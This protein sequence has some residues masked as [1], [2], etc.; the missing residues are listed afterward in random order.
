[1]ATSKT[2]EFE[3]YVKDLLECPGCS[4]S[5][6]LAPI[7]QCINGH[8]ICKHCIT[9]LEDCPICEN[10]SKIARNLVFEQIIGN[11][12][13]SQLIYEGSS[14]KPKLQKWGRGSVNAS[15]SNYGPNEGPNVHLNL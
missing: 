7:H 6:K 12:S 11:F 10:N 2:N 13:A 4:E 5:I 14:E 3:K 8:V 15:F 9:R 1:M